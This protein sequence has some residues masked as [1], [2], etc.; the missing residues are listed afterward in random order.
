MARTKRNASLAGDSPFRSLDRVLRQ[1]GIRL[2]DARPEPRPE[3]QAPAGVKSD[4]EVFEQAM[5]GVAPASWRGRRS[6]TS[7]PAPPVRAPAGD[8]STAIGNADA[9]NP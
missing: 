4:A 6:E 8:S 3:R 9:A 2:R 7:E 1:A 5:Q